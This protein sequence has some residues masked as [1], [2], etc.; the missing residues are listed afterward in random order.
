M[1]GQSQKLAMGGGDTA[2]LEVLQKTLFMQTEAAPG[3]AAYG[4]GCLVA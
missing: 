3:T 1:E 2:I 4:G